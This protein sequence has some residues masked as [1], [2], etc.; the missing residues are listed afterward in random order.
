MVKEKEEL[1]GIILFV[2]QETR[3]QT[4]ICWA[5]HHGPS[6]T[7]AT[8]KAMVSRTWE[9]MKKEGVG[10]GDD[11]QSQLVQATPRPVP[12]SDNRYDVMAS[13]RVAAGS[14]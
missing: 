4:R 14:R 9:A 12:F 8:I 11:E 1:F 13:R 5:V 2:T 6:T 3:Q 10:A 7:F